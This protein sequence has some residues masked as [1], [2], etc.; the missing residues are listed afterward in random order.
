MTNQIHALDDT[1]PHG[2]YR[3]MARDDFKKSKLMVDTTFQKLLLHFKT[4]KSID[5]EADE[6]HK[7]ILGAIKANQKSWMSYSY[8]YCRTKALIEV[9]PS[10]SMLFAQ[11]TNRCLATMNEKRIKYLKNLLQELKN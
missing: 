6:H 3:E 1:K 7:E 5:Q 9:F 11:V 2:Y 10:G 8:D 4:K